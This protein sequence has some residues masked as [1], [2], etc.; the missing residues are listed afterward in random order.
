MRVN[1]KHPKTRTDR[2]KKRIQEVKQQTE[3]SGFDV[4]MGENDNAERLD[5]TKAKRKQ[6]F[7]KSKSR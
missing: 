3:E 4:N 7:K 6:V 1:F 2:K 5:L